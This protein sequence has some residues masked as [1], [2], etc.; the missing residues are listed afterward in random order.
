MIEANNSSTSNFVDVKKFVGAARVHVLAVNPTNAIL[1]NYGWEI[2]DGAAEPQY[3]YVDENGKKFARVRFLVQVLNLK[4]KPVVPLDF[5]VRPDMIIGK[6]SGKYRVIDS[7]GRVAWASEEDIKAKPRRVPQ[8]T[9]GPANISADYKPCH[10]GQEKLIAFLYKYLN[11]TPLQ[12]FDKKSNQ[13]T[14]TK[15]PGHVY[16][17]DW[18][19]VCSGDMH[20]IEAGIKQAPNNEVYVVLGVKTTDENKTYQTFLDFCDGTSKVP[21]FGPNT[22][23]DEATGTF[24]IAQKRIDEFNNA[25]PNSNITFSAMPVHEWTETATDVKDNSGSMFDSEGNYTLADDDDLP[26][27]I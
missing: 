27:G 1:R 24:T 10:P 11:V 4:E 22:K 5:W 3:T 21:Y 17:D 2:A 20:E 15:N 23:L 7:Y 13:Y 12:I 9:N 25:F 14:A 18:A 6:T 8:Y 26:F 19:S 16:I